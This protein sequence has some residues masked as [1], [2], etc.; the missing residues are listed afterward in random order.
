MHE[1]AKFAERPYSPQEAET[2]EKRLQKRHHIITSILAP[3]LFR[4]KQIHF[5]MT[6]QLRIARA[7]LALLQYKQTNNAF[8]DTLEALKLSDISDPF[9][10]GPLSY[11]TEGQDFVLYSVGPD[12]KDNNGN[13]REKKQKEDWDIVWHFPGK[14]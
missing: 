1:G 3:A 4:V 8:P 2:L 12:Q 11:K 14:S 5:E 6:A 10:D 13:P 7:G 9:S